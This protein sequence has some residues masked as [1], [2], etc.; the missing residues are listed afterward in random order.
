MLALGL[1][2]STEAFAGNETATPSSGTPVSVS[3]LA[4]SKPEESWAGRT[5]GGQARWSKWAGTR[6]EPFDP[7]VRVHEPAFGELTDE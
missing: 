6:S 5:G 7:I 2:S 1:L 3:R 4:C